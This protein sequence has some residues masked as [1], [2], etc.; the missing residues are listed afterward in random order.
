MQI[1][2]RTRGDIA[3]RP[4]HWQRRLAPLADKLI[5][6][7]LAR[8][9]RNSSMLRA[10]LQSNGKGAPGFHVQLQLNL[11]GRRTA[12]AEAEAPSLRAAS[13]LAMR[14]LA[15]ETRRHFARLRHEDAW[16]RKARRERLQRIERSVA[17][18]EPAVRERVEHALQALHERLR[19]VAGH[20]LTLL[21][22]LG[23]LP[24]Q[25]PTVDDLVDETLAETRAAWQPGSDP[26]LLWPLLLKH[27]YQVIDREL[28]LSQQAARMASLDEPL[29]PDPEDQAEAMI[30]EEFFEYW[31]PD[32][33]TVLADVLAEDDAAEPVEEPAIAIDPAASAQALLADVVAALPR[34]WRRALL[35]ARSEGLAADQIAAVLDSQPETVQ[36]WIEQA[37]VFVQ[38]RFQ[39]A[40]IEVPGIRERHWLDTLLAP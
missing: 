26:D 5:G 17:T 27:L 16:K 24:D 11:P 18:L 19:E 33:E 20:E 31:Q 36:A 35:L 7:L 28:D 29:P 38:A 23:E 4:A 10:T 6:P 37:E 15:R 14:R 34:P 12:V 32:D 3:I 21:R 2:A 9:G 30:E 8:H 39:D 22:A 25:W 40:G 13:T 1:E